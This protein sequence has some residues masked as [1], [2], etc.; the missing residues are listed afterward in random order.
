MEQFLNNL[1]DTT[2]EEAQQIKPRKIDGL[3][4]MYNGQKE[5]P[6]KVWF[7]CDLREFHDDPNEIGLAYCHFDNALRA[8]YLP[9]GQQLQDPKLRNVAAYYKNGILYDFHAC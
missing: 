5:T 3:Y 4:F 8:V 2:R 9:D 6:G 7:G 1:P